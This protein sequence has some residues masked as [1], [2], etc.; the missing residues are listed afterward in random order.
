MRFVVKDEEESA[1]M[2]AKDLKT[3]QLFPRVGAETNF[4]RPKNQMGF[5]LWKFVSLCPKHLSTPPPHC[6]NSG[7]KC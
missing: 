4:F 3:N 2:G 6:R 7:R 1:K 5:Q